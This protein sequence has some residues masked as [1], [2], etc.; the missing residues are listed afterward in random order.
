MFV[1]CHGNQ[2]QVQLMILAVGLLS[3]A[4]V[5]ICSILVDFALPCPGFL[6]LSLD[7]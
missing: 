5:K 1:E 7:S 4:D 2:T 6:S 3:D